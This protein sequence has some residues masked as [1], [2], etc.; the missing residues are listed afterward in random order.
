LG[1]NKSNIEVHGDLSAFTR[2]I[3]NIISQRR[4]ERRGVFGWEMYYTL[5]VLS[6]SAREK[7]INSRQGAKNA[8]VF[9]VGTN[10]TW[11]YLATLA[12]LREKKTNKL[13]PGRKTRK[14]VPCKNKLNIEVLCDPCASAREKIIN[15]RQGA[16]YAKVFRIRTKYKLK[17]L[18]IL[19]ICERN[20][21]HNLAEAQGAQR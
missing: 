21:K 19:A 2:E 5:C 1:R 10:Q 20:K 17:Y 12:P 18:A 6:A 13:S 8:K 7:T 16:K 15:S 9:W 14:D 11:K 4:R 3:K